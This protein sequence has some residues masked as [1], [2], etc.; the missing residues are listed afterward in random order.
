[1]S[2]RAC[3]ICGSH[4]QVKDTTLSKEKGEKRVIPCCEQCFMT[5]RV[6]SLREYRLQPG[7]QAVHFPC[8]CM[9]ILEIQR[10]QECTT[11]PQCHREYRVDWEQEVL[12]MGEQE[13]HL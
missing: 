12:F 8:R 13:R 6:F 7:S 4:D 9:H 1:M 11:C 5:G 2:G 3:V 10:P